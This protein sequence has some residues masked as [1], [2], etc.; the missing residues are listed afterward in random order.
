MDSLDTLVD[1][2]VVGSAASGMTITIMKL[3]KGD[4]IVG[5]ATDTLAGESVNG[6]VDTEV[7]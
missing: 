7:S 4:V 6:S 3:L 1:R 2:L 5:A